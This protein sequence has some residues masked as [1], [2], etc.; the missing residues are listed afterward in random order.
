MNT[1]EIQNKIVRMVKRIKSPTI[2]QF[3]FIIVEGAFNDW[4]TYFEQVSK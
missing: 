1:N 4:V 3:I 2:L